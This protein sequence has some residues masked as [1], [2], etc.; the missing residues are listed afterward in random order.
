MSTTTM[1]KLGRQTQQGLDLYGAMRSSG[2]SR[3][4][5]KNR[6]L[7]LGARRA[8]LGVDIHRCTLLQQLITM[9]GG[10]GEIRWNLRACRSRSIGRRSAISACRYCASS[11]ARFTASVDAPASAPKDPGPAKPA[12]AGIHGGCDI[13]GR[14]RVPFRG[15]LDPGCR[16]VLAGTAGAGLG[17]ETRDAFS[18]RA[19]SAAA[20]GH[21]IIGPKAATTRAGAGAE[22]HGRQLM[23]LTP[24]ALAER[25][26][27]PTIPRSRI[28]IGCHACMARNSRSF[29]IGLIEKGRAPLRR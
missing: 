6:K 12:G 1:S 21:E 19:P 18:L 25:I 22:G 17:A 23:L 15:P 29:G 26:S 4:G 27:S 9:C 16:A 2:A 20:V 24:C 5:R 10:T 14:G 3:G 13:H 28:V 11:Q 8:C 7:A